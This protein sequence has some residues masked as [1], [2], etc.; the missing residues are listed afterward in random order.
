MRQ[1]VVAMGHLMYLLNFFLPSLLLPSL[2]RY[3]PTCLPPSFSSNYEKG[4]SDKS[5]R[6]F[7]ISEF[8]MK[9]DRESSFLRSIR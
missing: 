4:V 5:G 9:G 3:L 1:V 2:H 6:S 7:V 8:R